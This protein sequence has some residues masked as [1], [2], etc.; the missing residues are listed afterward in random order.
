VRFA[1]RHAARLAWGAR[2]L[3]LGPLDE[4]LVRRALD[5]LAE[6][7][8]GAG[9]GIVRLQASRDGEGRLHL[10][11]VPRPLGP[12]PAEWS[13]IV[14]QPPHDGGGL[15]PG[16][17][18]SSRLTMALAGDAA[19]GARA[20]EALLVDPA[21]WLVEGT[22]SNI[23]VVPEGA[24]P[25]TPPLD[26]G[27]VAGIARSLVLERVPEIAER[28]VSAAELIGAREI[29]AINTVR[30]ARPI[31]RLEDAPVGDGRPGPWAARLAAALA[32][33]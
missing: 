10:V 21:G 27:A 20:D 6:A 30:G 29:V 32:R 7:A 19:R 28:D 13:A 15:A 18:V 25:A 12:E 11:G 17:K 24:G 22:R 8:F 31:T 9:H 1:E 5:E 33:D 4:A 26:R 3:R 16:L 2:Q 14:V 23:V